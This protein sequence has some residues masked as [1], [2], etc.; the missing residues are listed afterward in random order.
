MKFDPSKS[1]STATCAA[2]PRK[3]CTHSGKH[4]TGTTMRLLWTVYKME[5]TTIAHF[6]KRLRLMTWSFRFKLF[7]GRFMLRPSVASIKTILHRPG[8]F[9]STFF[10]LW[11]VS[12][13]T[14]KLAMWAL[15]FSQ[16]MIYQMDGLFPPKSRHRKLW[17]AATVGITPILKIFFLEFL[18]PNHLLSVTK[19]LRSRFMRFCGIQTPHIAHRPLRYEW[20]TYMDFGV[21]GIK[22]HCID[23]VLLSVLLSTLKHLKNQSMVVWSLMVFQTRI[24]PA[25]DLFF[26]KKKDPLNRWSVSAVCWDSRSRY[27][28]CIIHLQ[29][30]PRIYPNSLTT[31]S[32]RSLEARLRTYRSVL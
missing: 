28:S 7:L 25:N 31:E 18:S 1:G 6:Q 32:C 27:L 4:F 22:P 23:P 8:F 17:S 12:K 15:L 29:M 30:N 2:F 19:R 5:N 13:K 24:Q 3:S 10:S 26:P 21:A 14:R 16:N 20:G 11:D 9:S